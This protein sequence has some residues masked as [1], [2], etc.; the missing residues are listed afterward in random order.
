MEPEV[1]QS[2]LEVLMLLTPMILAALLIRLLPM[3]IRNFQA[4]YLIL[5]AAWIGIHSYFFP[6]IGILPPIIILVMGEVF[7]F[8]AMGILG[9]RLGNANYG[10]IL[11]AVGFF[12]WYLGVG[13]SLIYVLGV[14]LVASL[15]AWTKFKLATKKYGIGNSRVEVVKQRLSEEAFA[16]F[17][18]KASVIFSL[19]IALTAFVVVALSYGV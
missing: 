13:T 10:S 4:A 17:S 18:R 16:D 11:I 7:L 8:L 2:L 1:N 9:T 12:P 5:G 6:Q 19:P 15:V 14:L 3:P